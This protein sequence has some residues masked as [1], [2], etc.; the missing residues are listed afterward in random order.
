MT[1]IG[2][3]FTVRFMRNGDTITFVRNVLKAS[4]EGASLFQ[5][6]DT[7]SGAVAPDWTQAANQPIIR[8]TPRSA[9][10]YPVSI[11]SVIWAY[12]G[13]S[14]SFTFDGTNWVNENTAAYKNVFQAR[15]NADGN[16]EL[17]IINNLASKDAVSNRQISYAVDYVTAAHH[18]TWEGSV[19]V[20]IQQAGANSHMIQIAIDNV[21]LSGESGAA[22]Y[23]AT[24]TVEA[25]YGI[26]KVTI[27]SDGYTTKWYKDGTDNTNLIEGSEGKTSLVVTRADIDGGGIYICKLFLNGNAVAQDQQRISDIS[28]EYQIESTVAS[29]SVNFVSLSNSAVYNLRVK[30]NGKEMESSEWNI[31]WDV[32][33]AWAEITKHGEG[34]TVTIDAEDCKRKGGDEYSDVDV[35]VTAD[36]K[37]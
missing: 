27:G 6:I 25:Y 9:A 36:S 11:S 12:A 16:P 23:Q 31:A 14:L 2:A 19:D 18:E 26:N 34:T 5:T 4:G 8:L 35:A 32:Y 1:N 30:K 22:T 15:F 37:V 17:K 13:V 24:M 28:D 10:G 21:E 3:A 33:N 7:T 20:L 29:T